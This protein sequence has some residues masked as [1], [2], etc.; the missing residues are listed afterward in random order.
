MPLRRNK[1]RMKAEIVLDET[2]YGIPDAGKPEYVFYKVHDDGEEFITT[3][4]VPILYAVTKEQYN[5]WVKADIQ[6]K[7]D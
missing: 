3:R 4:S 1:K 5:N 7:K 6:F 2:K